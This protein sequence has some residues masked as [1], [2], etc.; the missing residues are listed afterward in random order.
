MKTSERTAPE[1]RKF[2]GA[3]LYV[4]TN[5]GY[6]KILIREIEPTGDLFKVSGEVLEGTETSRMFH[7]TDTKDLTGRFVS[8]YA[9]SQS[10]LQS[11]RHDASFAG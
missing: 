1:S 9:V 10:S 4:K 6:M 2:I 7:Y 8:V 11:A 3:T 5:H